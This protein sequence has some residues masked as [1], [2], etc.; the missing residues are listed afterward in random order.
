MKQHTGSGKIQQ[1]TIDDLHPVPGPMN[2]KE[3]EPGQ[4]S[5]DKEILGQ[6]RP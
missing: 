4:N 1:E 6:I 2:I 5:I 3:R